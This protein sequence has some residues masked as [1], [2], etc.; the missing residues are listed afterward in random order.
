MRIYIA[1]LSYDTTDAQLRDLF[2]AFGD[3]T[4]ATII[5]D[6]ETQKPR[7]IG[8]VEIPDSDHAVQAI[9]GLNGQTFMGRALRVA[10]AIDRPKSQKA[11]R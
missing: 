8:F 4:K 7:G 1:N 9:K 10:E 2:Q 6:K 5:Y 11:G 3:V